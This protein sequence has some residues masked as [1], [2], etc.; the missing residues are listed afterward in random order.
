M[1]MNLLFVQI[2]G[3]ILVTTSCKK[4]A[5]NPDGNEPEKNVA[6]G[7]VTDTQARPLKGVSILIDNTIIYNSYISG[8]TADDGSYKIALRNGAWR[9]YA[10]M[11]VLFNGKTYSVDLHPDNSEGFGGEGAVRNFSW[12]LTGR[13]AEPL[14]G[15]YGGTVLVDK[16]VLS[17]IYDAENIEFTMTPVG[18]LI[19]GSAGQVI[20]IKPGMPGSA[21]Q[22]KL[23]D[24]P[25][26]RYTVTAIYHS[27]SGN[28]PVKLRDRINNANG[29]FVASL[30]LDFEPATNN[31]DNMA[32]LEYREN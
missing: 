19:D 17:T 31:G 22:D 5:N 1:R 3:V 18:N 14:A 12:K 9:A 16:H 2:I 10:R 30:Q 29:P 8:T 6:K 24:L 32:M 28:I 15:V 13:K 11:K 7:R 20:R 25:I 4:N 21:T 27:S 23:Y 26:G